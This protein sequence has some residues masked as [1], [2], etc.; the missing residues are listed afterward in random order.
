MAGPDLAWPGDLNAIPLLK[1]MP[2]ADRH[3]LSKQLEPRQVFN[4]MR[5]LVHRLNTVR[6][7]Q[8]LQTLMIT[9]AGPGEGKTTLSVNLAAM[10]ASQGHRVLL[11]DADVRAPKVSQLLVD[12]DLPGLVEV[13]GQGRS[14]SEALVRI[15]PLSFVVLPAGERLEAAEHVVEDPK[16]RA[17]LRSAKL[18]FD[19]IIVDNSPLQY[20]AD[21]HLVSAMVDGSLLVVRAG[22]TKR[23]DYQYAVSCLAEGRLIGSVLNDFTGEAENYYQ[24]YPIAPKPL[25]LGNHRTIEIH[26]EENA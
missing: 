3:I 23:A 12:V 14:L 19:W 20:C 1:C 26:G 15:S 16:F 13:I 17:I 24:G 10:L 5:L 2:C 11:I 4:S 25:A 21:P 7:R 22:H 6:D 9:S 8:A 18:H